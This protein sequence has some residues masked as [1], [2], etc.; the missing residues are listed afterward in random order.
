MPTIATSSCPLGRRRRTP[1]RLSHRHPRSPHEPPPSK[2]PRVLPLSFFCRPFG[3]RVPRCRARP[4][5]CFVRGRF[6]RQRRARHRPGRSRRGRPSRR[7]RVFWRRLFLG[8]LP[9]GL[10][11]IEDAAVG[12]IDFPDRDQIV[13]ASATGNRVRVLT[14]RPLR[15]PLV[16]RAECLYARHRSAPGGASPRPGG[17][18]SGEGGAQADFAVGTQSDGDG[19]IPRLHYLRNAD[20]VTLLTSVNLPVPARPLRH[21]PNRVRSISPALALPTFTDSGGLFRLINS[22]GAPPLS[23]AL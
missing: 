10:P 5:S 14:P 3:C 1:R 2:S 21:L 4:A 6:Q 12:R 13:L 22:P 7:L 18:A 11:S 19:L 8:N 23:L 9:S 15:S 16:P 20:P 17:G